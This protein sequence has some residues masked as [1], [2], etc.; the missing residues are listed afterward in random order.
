M[1]NKIITEIKEA[2][3]IMVA[4]LDDGILLKTV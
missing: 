2:Q 3:C 1:K 4:M